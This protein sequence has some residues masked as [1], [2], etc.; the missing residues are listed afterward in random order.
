M[1]LDHPTML[2]SSVS[3]TVAAVITTAGVN[4]NSVSVSAA[5]AGIS[6]DGLA[7][8]SADA[9]SIAASCAT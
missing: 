5:E 3:G 6:A 9:S 2:G 4:L 7:G 8:L 1:N